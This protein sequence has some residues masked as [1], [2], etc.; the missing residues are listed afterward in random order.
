LL[1]ASISGT[2]KTKNKNRKKTL[3]FRL[4]DSV[5]VALLFSR[6]KKL[7]NDPTKV[8]R[9]AWAEFYAVFYCSCVLLHLVRLAPMGGEGYALTTGG[10][11]G[12]DDR[13]TGVEPAQSAQA[14]RPQRRGAARHGGGRRAT[15]PASGLGQRYCYYHGL[16]RPRA[17]C[18]LPV[19]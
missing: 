1:F 12:G 14:A 15:R 2:K 6:M 9:C 8:V 3:Y 16:L 5:G 17:T 4:V 13:G 10:T 11:G 19:S 18:R 7:L